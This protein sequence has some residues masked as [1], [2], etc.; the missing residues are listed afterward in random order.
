MLSTTTTTNHTVSQP[1]ST[2][3]QAHCR[4]CGRLR[5]AQERFL[6]S[7]RGI[8]NIEDAAVTS[9][10]SPPKPSPLL[11]VRFRIRDIHCRIS[12]V[13]SAQDM[14]R[15]PPHMHRHATVSECHNRPKS[16]YATSELQRLSSR[17][18]VTTRL[19][20]ALEILL[21]FATLAHGVPSPAVE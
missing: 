15:N 10:H 6:T 21:R 1:D 2:C 19:V 4:S 3:N 8:C 20:N 16:D 17:E 5:K 7:L 12:G 9:V 14:M 11:D 18:R 13:E